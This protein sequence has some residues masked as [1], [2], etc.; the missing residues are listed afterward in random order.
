MRQKMKWTLATLILISV[1]CFLFGEVTA[2]W[3]E[4]KEGGELPY[5]DDMYTDNMY[6]FSSSLYDPIQNCVYMGYADVPTSVAGLWKYDLNTNQFTEYPITNMPSHD[7]SMVTLD[8]VNNRIIMIDVHD[9]TIYAVSTT[10]GAL[11]LLGGGGIY[12]WSMFGRSHFQNP[13]TNN[14]VIMNGYGGYTVKNPVMEYNLATSTWITR[15]PDRSDQPWRRASASITTNADKSKVFMFGGFAKQSGSQAGNQ[16]PGFLPW[17][18]DIGY[19]NWQRDLWALDLSTWQWTNLL[20]PNSS[21]IT[22]EGSICYIDSS[23]TIIMIGGY[24]PAPVWGNAP[25]YVGNVYQY[26][27]GVDVGFNQIPVTGQ[28]PPVP[29]TA[30]YSDGAAIFDA[31]NNRIVYFRYDGIWALNLNGINFQASITEGLAPLQTT[32]EITAGYESSS[33]VSWDFENDGIYDS[34]EIQPVHTYTVPGS[35]SVKVRIQNGAEVDSLIKPNYITVNGVPA[36]NVQ[37]EQLSINLNQANPT[38]NTSL[39]ISNIGWGPLE[40][41]ISSTDTSSGYNVPTD[42]LVAHYPFNNNANDESGNNFNLTNY[43]ANLVEDRY[44]NPNQAYHFNGSTYLETDSNLGI[45]CGDVTISAWYKPL[46]ISHSQTAPNG[47]AGIAATYD[48]ATNTENRLYHTGSG[49]PNNFGC[50]VHRPYVGVWG[51]DGSYSLGDWYHMVYTK[52][53]QNISLYINGSLI[54]TAASP[55]IT[56]STVTNVRTRIGM[57]SA[58][59]MY[60]RIIGDVDDVFFYNRALS[61]TEVEDLYIATSPLL[62]FNPSTGTV[63][64]NS[65]NTINTL[66]NGLGLSDGIHEYSIIINSN[67]PNSPLTIPLTINVD[68]TPPAAPAGLAFEETLSDMN[69]IYL[70]WTSNALPDSVLTYKVYRRGIH[71]VEWSLKGSVNANHNWFLD[72]QF[73]GLDTTA[74]YYKIRAVDWL[75]NE[76]PDSNE[77]LAWLLRFRSPE[78]V[79]IENINNQHIHLT[80]NP[81]TQTI[82]GLPGTPSCYVIYKSQYPTPITDFDFLGVSFA[83]E[84]THQWALYFQPA[85]RLFYIVT[86]YGGNMSRLDQILAERNAWSYE[87]L[88]SMLQD[89]QINY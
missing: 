18:S 44:G 10:G 77:V 16:D 26:R 12:S 50:G 25:V 89:L 27:L 31:T 63:N 43:G 61:L 62:T 60:N 4:L 64:P 8:Q 56:S 51:I 65:S 13:Y 14:P 37:P 2:T 23:N 32:F 70:T 83:N 59:T 66:V 1:G 29:P 55:A 79:A 52:N 34:N 72:N 40:F 86:A 11:T 3:T 46:S 84:F 41:S 87:E 75:G 22:S 76:S 30:N 69:Q 38:G 19:W 15:F 73:T 21:S 36:I 48:F 74:V 39:N 33:I 57:G 42:G 24:I 81:V 67:D 35:Y 6:D 80:W 85:N 78:N 20:G 71:E 53:N 17:A 7:C 45:G 88:E 49:V 68:F 28:I 82:S 9:Q 5:V 47:D 58:T 54:G